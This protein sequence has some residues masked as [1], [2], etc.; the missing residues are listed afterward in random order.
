[1]PGNIIGARPHGPADSTGTTRHSERP[2]DLTVRDNLTP[3]HTTNQRVNVGEDGSEFWGA[4]DE[5]LAGSARGYKRDS[6]GLGT[7]GDLISS[8]GFKFFLNTVFLL[9]G[10]EKPY[11]RMDFSA[12]LSNKLLQESLS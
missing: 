7:R 8:H 9:S 6:T 5:A 10:R 3:G 1:M 4:L 11:F 12:I 2:R